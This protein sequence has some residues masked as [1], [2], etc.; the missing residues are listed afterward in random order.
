MSPLIDT[1]ILVRLTDTKS[2]DHPLAL[3]AINK[4]LAQGEDGIL[5]PQTL[6]EFWAVATRPIAANGLGLSPALA[7][8]E[9]VRYQ[10]IFSLRPDPPGLYDRWVQLV[11]AYGVSGKQV[12]DTRLVAFL[13]EQGIGHVLTFNVPD[14]ARFAAITAVHPSAV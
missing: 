13:L 8:R 1:S 3:Q 7:E 4:L 5:A 9:R 12:H 11:N 14:F 2:L 10:G 6:V